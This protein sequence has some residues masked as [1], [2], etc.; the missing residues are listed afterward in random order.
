MRQHHRPAIAPLHRQQEGFPAQVVVIAA[1]RARREEH[2]PPCAVLEFDELRMPGRGDRRSARRVQV[3]LG[4]HRIAAPGLVWPGDLA[5]AVDHLRMLLAGAAFGRGEV[6]VAIAAEQM[7]AFD[8][9]GIGRRREAGIHDHLTGADQR[10]AGQIQLL[11]PDGAVPVVAH[12]ACGHVVV[13][14]P[15]AAIVIEKQRGIDALGVQPDRVRP[16]PGRIG[17]GDQEIAAIAVKTGVGDIEGAGV[18]ADAGGKQAAGQFVV[19]VVDL[20]WTVDR[21]ADLV[22]VHQVAALEDRQAGKV[23]ETGIHQIKIVADAHRRRVRMKTGHDRIAVLRGS[24]YGATIVA[25]VIDLRDQRGAGLCQPTAQCGQQAGH[26]CE[27]FQEIPVCH[28]LAQRQY[29]TSMTARRAAWH[30]VLQCQRCVMACL[31]ARGGVW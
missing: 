9:F 18:V 8:V 22:P 6:V 16:R 19:A 4:E 31:H 20:G 23:A 25:L 10:H 12:L 14:Q 3:A 15:G 21:V 26:P 28:A 29:D 11:Q 2:R 17:G 27:S 5:A 13:D 1:V 30:D 24:W 7:R